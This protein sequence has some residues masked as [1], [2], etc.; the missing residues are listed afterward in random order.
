[1]KSKHSTKFPGF[2]QIMSKQQVELKNKQN[3]AYS[4]M[5]QGI[6]IFLTGPA[7]VGKT[8][9][10]K[11]YVNTY[12]GSRR[13]AITSTT[14][15]SALLIG[16]TTV[17]SYLGI[18]LGR[19]SAETLI[20]KIYASKWYRKRWQELDCLIIDEISMM[21]PEL[22]DKLENV[23]RA[24]R[25]STYP[26][27]GIQLV[28]SG[29]FAQLP[30]V[31]SHKFC[32]EAETWEKC[33]TE[34]IY[35]SEIMRQTNTEFQE[36]LNL[37]RLGQVTP[38]VVDILNSRVGASLVNDYGIKPTRLYSKNVD[39]DRVNDQELDRLASDGREFA[40]YVMEISVYTKPADVVKTMEKFRKNCNA[41]QVLQLCVGS[42][43]MLLKNLDL[44]AGLAN[45][46]RGVVSSFVE[47]IPMVKFING[48]ERLIDYHIWL[49]EENGEE[50]LRAQQI[51]LRV[52]Y[53]ITIHKSQGCSLDYVEVDLTECFEYGQAYVALS[54]AKSLE[55]LSIKGI[56]YDYIKAHPKAIRYYNSLV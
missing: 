37:I 21:D 51:P 4:R 42:Q 56:D 38:W 7:G 14:G 29:D 18:G 54:R 47:D 1:M 48:V 11:A 46:S 16:G 17:H 49:V 19:D 3:Y 20:N 23:A 40:E 8:A 50:V 41:P 24:I 55:G 27:G 26:F 12:S 52:A 5:A 36:C 32:F 30:V 44:E 45:G 2:L 22:F 10:I 35:L 34:T 13:I 6:S 9:C 15:S 39:V 31:N 25:G 28:L 43:V 53:A 33:V